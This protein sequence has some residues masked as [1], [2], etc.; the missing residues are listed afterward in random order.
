M[1]ENEIKNTESSNTKASVK[2]NRFK[3]VI[4][5]VALL[6][7]VGMILNATGVFDRLNITDETFTNAVNAIGGALVAL[8]ILNNPSDPNNF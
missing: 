2:Q 3:S 5:W 4:T 7:A 1:I 8:G 6:G